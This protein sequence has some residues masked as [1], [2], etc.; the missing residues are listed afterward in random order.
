MEGKVQCD[1]TQNIAC[2]V[3]GEGD[4]A[5][6]KGEGGLGVGAGDTWEVRAASLPADAWLAAQAA[7]ET[8][9][10]VGRSAAV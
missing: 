3:Q 1:L 7:S 6:G 9:P 5:T 10:L 4:G 2:S 8:W